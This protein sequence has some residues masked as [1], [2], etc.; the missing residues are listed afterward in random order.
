RSAAGRLL[1]PDD[2]HGPPGRGL[3]PLR[4]PV[5]ERSGGPDAQVAFRWRRTLS[6]RSLGSS[7]SSRWAAATILP[8]RGQ[9][10]KA[11]LLTTGTIFGLFSLGHIVELITRW[12]SPASDPWF[13]GGMALIVVLSAAL[14]SEE[15]T[16]ELQSRGH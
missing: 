5:C 14:R 8:L 3:S 12:Q 4:D 1:P 10:V 9:G 7:P 6:S 16:S 2:R 15:H 13:M 11:Y